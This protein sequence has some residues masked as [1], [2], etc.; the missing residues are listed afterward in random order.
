MATS[1]IDRDRLAA[2][3]GAKPLA[4]AEQQM[5]ANV[6]AVIAAACATADGY[7]RKQVAMPPSTEAIDQVAPIVAEL[8]Y[9]GLK[10]NVPNP[11]LTKRRE[12]ALRAL[13]DIASGALVLHTTPT[14]DDPA[15]PEDESA[16]AGPACGSA[17]RR[18]TRTQLTDW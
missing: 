4:D 3:V 8:V 13:R 12:M 16:E 14:V 7:V 6:D 18:M 1:Y 9:T 17:P 2:L 5:G 10:A 11:E 15:T